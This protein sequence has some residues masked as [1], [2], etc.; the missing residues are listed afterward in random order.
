MPNIQ[1]ALVRKNGLIEKFKID[2]VK[3]KSLFSELADKYNT[4]NPYHN[5]IHACDVMQTI[6]Y[7]ITRGGFG[8]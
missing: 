4:A 5:S 2:E 6:N 1:Q 3:L 8:Q 7:M